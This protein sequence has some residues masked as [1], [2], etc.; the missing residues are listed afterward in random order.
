METSEIQKGNATA[1]LDNKKANKL[2]LL[3]LLLYFGP[4]FI[5]G[6]LLA[7]HFLFQKIPGMSLFRSFLYILSSLV[8]FTSFGCE[9]AAIVLMIYVRVTYPKNTFGKILMWVYIAFFVLTVVAIILLAWFC[10]D[11]IQS[12]SW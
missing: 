8:E 11:M 4:G 2:S 3:S 6:L 10:I 9:I 7:L 1:E 12:C 5:C